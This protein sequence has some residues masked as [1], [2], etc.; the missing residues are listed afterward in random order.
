MIARFLPLFLSLLA[1]ATHASPPNVLFIAVDDLRP[2]HGV[3][4]GAAITPRASIRTVGHLFWKDRSYRS[5]QA[6]DDAWNVVSR[7][8]RFDGP[9]PDTGA[10]NGRQ[11]MC[12]SR[13]Q[14]ERRR[15]QI[16]P[17]CKSWHVDRRRS[18][19]Y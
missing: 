12:G 13:Q 5:A 14:L 2:E 1:G 19:P 9:H 8:R 3:F 7:G 6:A 4:G 15:V 11:A 10:Q 17:A 18:H 16:V